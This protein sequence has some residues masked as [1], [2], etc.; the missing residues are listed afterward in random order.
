[1]IQIMEV[2]TWEV[3]A[4]L[5]PEDPIRNGTIA[6]IDFS[7]DDKSLYVAAEATDQSSGTV[8]LFHVSFEGAVLDRLTVNTAEDTWPSSIPKR[9]VKM[10]PYEDPKQG[11][12]VLLKVEAG[13]HQSIQEVEY[14]INGQAGVVYSV[15]RDVSFDTCKSSGTYHTALSVACVAT[16]KDG[17]CFRY[18]G[19]CDLTVGRTSREDSD[20]TYAIYVADDNGSDTEDGW[21]YGATA[22][23]NEFDRYS[24][25]QYYWAEPRFF[26]DDAMHFGDS[27]DLAIVFAHG[28]PH[29][30][31]TGNG[32]VDLSNTAFG[33][34]A[35]C[36][37]VGDLEYL[38]LASCSVLSVDSESFWYY[39]IHSFDT[40]F[41]ERPFT[42]LHQVLGFRT[43]YVD[44]YLHIGDWRID[45]NGADFF[46]EFANHLDIGF[47]VRDAW[48]TAAEEELDF[49][50]GNN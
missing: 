21:I 2:G 42:G 11:D 24:L 43:K 3:I 29:I 44:N 19:S 6:A 48:N 49:D 9:W 36:Y 23:I 7:P 18:D 35:H 8:E 22:F 15:P 32:T 26:T 50:D 25:S 38:A 28:S 47:A 33:S 5:R 20:K 27:V 13:D 16:Y 39:W 40:R 30:F 1:M 14:S 37:Q 17:E 31:D 45:D 41:S 4:A 46:Q 12:R 10:S 34:L